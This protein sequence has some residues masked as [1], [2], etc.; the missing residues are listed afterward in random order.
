MVT[1]SDGLAFNKVWAVAAGAP[2]IRF[3]GAAKGPGFQ[4][5]GAVWINNTLLVVYSI[6]KEDIGL[7]AIPLQLLS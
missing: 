7:T 6:N 1:D 5:P 4:Y 2:P 3:P